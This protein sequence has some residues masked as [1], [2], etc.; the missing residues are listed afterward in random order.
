M[1]HA[2]KV[3]TYDLCLSSKNVIGRTHFCTCFMLERSRPMTAT[4]WL[5]DIRAICSLK[6]KLSYHHLMKCHLIIILDSKEFRESRNKTCILMSIKKSEIMRT[7]EGWLTL[8]LGPSPDSCTP[9]PPSPF[10]KIVGLTVKQLWLKSKDL[11]IDNKI[12]RNI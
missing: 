11:H 3:Q 10:C 4:V 8:L 6:I 5:P 2:V 7:K 12:A 9:S 1:L